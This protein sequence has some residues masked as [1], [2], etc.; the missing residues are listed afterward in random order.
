MTWVG[1]IE[2]ATQA[3][4]AALPARAMLGLFLSADADAADGGF[5]MTLSSGLGQLLTSWRG[6]FEDAVVA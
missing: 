2:A 1:P 3:D 5:S 4:L 6:D